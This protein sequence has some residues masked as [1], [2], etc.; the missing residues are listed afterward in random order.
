M[1]ADDNRIASGSGP[2]WVDGPAAVLNF[3][4]PQYNLAALAGQ[5]LEMAGIETKMWQS[6]IGQAARNCDRDLREYF[7]RRQD[8][9]HL[10]W[11]KAYSR[12]WLNEHWGLG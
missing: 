10:R 5:D 7:R 4:P 6:L 3:P 9:A 2:D 12:K 8:I 11:E 1:N